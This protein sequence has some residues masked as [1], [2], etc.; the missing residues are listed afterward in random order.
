M[1]FG[2]QNILENETL[3]IL[4][5]KDLKQHSETI[6][7]RCKPRIDNDKILVIVHN[8]FDAREFFEEELMK[9]IISIKDH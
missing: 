5:L 9:G 4:P 7:C 8:A 6:Y 2:W 3:N 1:N